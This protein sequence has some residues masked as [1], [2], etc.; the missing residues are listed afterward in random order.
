MSFA[1]ARRHASIALNATR[2]SSTGRS[3]KNLLEDRVPVSTPDTDPSNGSSWSLFGPQDE[4]DGASSSSGHNERSLSPRAREKLPE[5]SSHQSIPDTVTFVKSSGL[6]LGL[7][8]LAHI[9][10]E[11]R[12]GWQRHRYCE[13]L[14]NYLVYPMC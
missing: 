9:G 2:R 3:G 6:T 11:V 8:Y 4:T 14:Y 7:Q 5:D 12:H 13:T 1:L 10:S